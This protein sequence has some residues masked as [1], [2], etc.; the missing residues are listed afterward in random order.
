MQMYEQIIFNLTEVL[1]S[2]NLDLYLSEQRIK[3]LEKRIT[4]LEREIG[5]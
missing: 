3:D 1:K 2:K 4:E 5:E